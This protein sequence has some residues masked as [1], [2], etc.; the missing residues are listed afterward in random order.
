M[1]KAFPCAVAPAAA[2]HELPE[3]ASLPVQTIYQMNDADRM[4][5]MQVAGIPSLIIA[6]VMK[7]RI[8]RFEKEIMT[9]FLAIGQE[10]PARV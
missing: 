3:H 10:V 5:F 6:L 2:R 1:F 7:G 4:K 9:P 8:R